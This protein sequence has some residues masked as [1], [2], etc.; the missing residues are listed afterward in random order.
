MAAHKVTIK[1]THE[2]QKQ[3]KDATGKSITELNIDVSSMGGLSDSDLDK[4]AGGATLY[5]GLVYHPQNLIALVWM[6][7]HPNHCLTAGRTLNASASLWP[8]E[9]LSAPRRDNKLAL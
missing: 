9:L 8:S 4:V 3:F 7:P 6:A 1:L 2:Q 5:K